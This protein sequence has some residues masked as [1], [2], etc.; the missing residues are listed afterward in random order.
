MD[1]QNHGLSDT[2]YQYTGVKIDECK[3]WL[4]C[5]QLVNQRNAIDQYITKNWK[6]WDLVKFVTGYERWNPVK[7]M[8]EMDE[9]NYITP[10]TLRAFGFP[11]Y[12]VHIEPI[13]VG[14]AWY[15]WVVSLPDYVAE[16]MKSEF[17]DTII[18][19][20]ANGFG[21]YLCKDGMLKDGIIELFGFIG[22]THL[23]RQGEIVW[24]DK[25]LISNIRFYFTQKRY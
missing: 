10:Q 4:E 1:R 20:P 22:G 8:D 19:G 12:F 5:I 21:L 2:V 6:Y 7:G 25:G 16:G 11:I 17:N 3:T 9:G 14:A 13:P 15:E 24:P 23:Y 18:V